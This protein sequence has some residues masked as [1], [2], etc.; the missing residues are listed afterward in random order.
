MSQKDGMKVLIAAGSS[1]GHIFPAIATTFRLKELN[2]STE[3]RFV[4]SGKKLDGDIFKNE[5]YDYYTVSSKRRIF[6]DLFS[7]FFILRKFQPD[8]AVGFGGYVSFPVLIMAKLLGIPTMAHEQNLCPGLANRILSNLVDR[9]AVSFK[10][11]NNFFLR[12]SIIEETGNPLRA[13]LV[14]LDKAKALER[15]GL[16]Q[17]KFT[18]LVMGGSQGAHFVNEIVLEALN[19]MSDAQKGRLQVIHLSG[20]IDF[21][22]VKA[23][24]ESIS[25]ANKVFSFFDMMSQAYS[26]C[27]LVISRAGATSIAELTFFGRPAILIPYPNA[28]VH[29]IDNARFMEEN[30]A[31]IVIEQRHLS[32]ER[33]K[34]ALLGLMDD[35]DALKRMSETSSRLSKPDAAYRLAV[36]IFN[37]VKD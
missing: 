32:R 7:A 15:F 28:K 25:V 27:D 30:G 16:N 33:L 24:Y 4:G 35:K 5:G 19:D 1:G 31:A 17:G 13:N 11:T 6:K 3:I 26:A 9:V 2:K 36:E 37:A 29:Q 20:I 21:E 22:F 34:T 18:M 14:K 12:K 23:R 8:I 10:E